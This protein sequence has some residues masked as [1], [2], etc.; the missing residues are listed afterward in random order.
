MINLTEQEAARLRLKA[1][2]GVLE[3]HEEALWVEYQNQVAYDR[4]LDIRR[5]MKADKPKKTKKPLSKWE[6]LI[7]VGV[8][9]CIAMI[10]GIVWVVSNIDSP[11][12]RNGPTIETYAVD[13]VTFNQRIQD[14]HTKY[15]EVSDIGE[16]YGTDKEVAFADI[17]SCTLNIIIRDRAS[18]VTVFLSGES[19]TEKYRNLVHNVM[20][21]LQPDAEDGAVDK[22]FDAAVENNEPVALGDGIIQYNGNSLEVRMDF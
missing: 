15:S 6:I 2:H 22:A 21:V 12:I 4:G 3:P 19:K 17:G 7:I 13:K 20:K 11:M 5:E 8:F 14:F 9:F 16:L 18:S 10:G 1:K